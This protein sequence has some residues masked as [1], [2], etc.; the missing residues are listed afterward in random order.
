M[1]PNKTGPQ[2]IMSQNSIITS[3]GFFA[4]NLRFTCTNVSMCHSSKRYNFSR[5]VRLSNL[6][7][8]LI[9]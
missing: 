6:N 8:T 9:L 3:S 5:V 1:G 7:Y 4:F 2:I